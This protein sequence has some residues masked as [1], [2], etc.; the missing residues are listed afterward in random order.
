M[1]LR[2]VPDS[3]PALHRKFPGA[4]L[5][6]TALHCPRCDSGIRA[7][8]SGEVPLFAPA[9]GDGL[10]CFIADAPRHADHPRPPRRAGSSTGSAPL[11]AGPA[12]G[13][14]WRVGPIRTGSGTRRPGG[15]GVYAPATVPSPTVEVGPPNP[16]KVAPRGARRQC[17]VR[18]ARQAIDIQPDPCAIFTIGAC[19]PW[20]R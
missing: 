9:E 15:T 11:G 2:T 1:R 20:V 6:L 14:R 3:H 7:S 8:Y 12:P 17:T 19:R 5:R 4:T 18:L 16:R 13:S 10:Q